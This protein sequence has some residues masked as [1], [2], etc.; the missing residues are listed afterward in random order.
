MTIRPERKNIVYITEAFREDTICFLVRSKSSFI[1]FRDFENSTIAFD[2]EPLNVRLLHP[3]V[4]NAKL[5]IIESPKQRIEAVCQGRA[6]TLNILD[7]IGTEKAQVAKAEGE[8]R[9]QTAILQSIPMGEG[10]VVADENG[11]FLLFNSAAERI[12][13]SG[14]SESTP[15][16]WNEH[17][18]FTCRTR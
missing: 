16:H 15:G 12:L 7:D 4:P 8:L 3:Y 9:K 11:S 1:R 18:S 10:V 13:G 2:G 6:A 17:T 5:V 14:P